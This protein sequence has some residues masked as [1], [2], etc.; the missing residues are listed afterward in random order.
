MF[1]VGLDKSFGEKNVFLGAKKVSR[2][3]RAKFG[4]W[5]GLSLRK[6]QQ[7]VQVYNMLFYPWARRFAR[8]HDP[9]GGARNSLSCYCQLVCMT[10][11]A[12]LHLRAAYAAPSASIWVSDSGGIAAVSNQHSLMN[13]E[14]GAACRVHASTHACQHPL[15][16]TR[17][18]KQNV[19]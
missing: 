12:R 8:R 17:T 5:E 9:N 6:D 19:N 16:Q 11:L 2:F 18:H 4:V 13:L 10:G 1:S 14:E 3:L 7:S 15:I